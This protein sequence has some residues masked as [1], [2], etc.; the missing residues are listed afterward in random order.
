MRAR[1]RVRSLA[2]SLSASLGPRAFREVIVA[3]DRAEALGL[4]HLGDLVRALQVDRDRPLTPFG[5]F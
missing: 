5:A 3:H 2:L 4:D 1:A